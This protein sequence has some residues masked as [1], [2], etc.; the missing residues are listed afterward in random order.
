MLLDKGQIVFSGDV[1]ET[2]NR[3]LEGQL[4][5]TMVDRVG[6]GDVRFENYKVEKDIIQ[7][8]DDLTVTFDIVVNNKIYSPIVCCVDVIN[9]SFQ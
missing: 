4:N 3:Y 7:L 5:G 9:S 2:V 6:S 1:N 8:G